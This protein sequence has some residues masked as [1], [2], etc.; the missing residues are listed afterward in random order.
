LKFSLFEL[1]FVF[2]GAEI[3]EIARVVFFENLRGVV[4][5]ECFGFGFFFADGCG[6]GAENVHES[7][8]ACEHDDA[9]DDHS[10]FE[11]VIHSRYGS[12]IGFDL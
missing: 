5:T 8:A 9:E 3:D 6:Y 7:A 2:G 1:R 10:K 4:V 11:P 12:I